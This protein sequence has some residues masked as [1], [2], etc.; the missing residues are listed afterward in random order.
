MDA[1]LLGNQHCST[2]SM[3]RL[4][5]VSV[6]QLISRF[7]DHAL[8]A[9][10]CS[11]KLFVSRDQDRDSIDQTVYCCQQSVSRELC[12]LKVPRNLSAES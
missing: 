2:V 7:H 9:L 10:D 6:A 12:I 5:E 8:E 3:P 4:L 11:M 1:H